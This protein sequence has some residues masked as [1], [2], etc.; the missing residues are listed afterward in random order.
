MALFEVSG[1]P[2]PIPKLDSRPKEMMS[3]NQ[4]ESGKWDIR[5]NA[6]SLNLLQTCLRKCQ[7][8]LFEGL[9]AKHEST[10]TLFGSAIHSAMEVFYSAPRNDRTIPPNMTKNLELMAH[11]EPVPVENDFLVYRAT[12]AFIDRAAPL[13]ALPPEDKR[14]IPNGVWTLGH[15]WKTYIQELND[16][17]VVVS[18]DGSP[19]VEKR[20]EHTFYDKDDMNI[21]LFGTIDAILENESNGQILIADHKTSSVVGKDFYNRLKPNH[22]YTCYTYLAQKCLGILTDNFLVNCIQ[23]KPKPKTARGQA[24]HFP[25]QI[26]KRTEED[27][28]HFLKTVE[29]YCRVAIS[30]KETGYWPMGPVEAC[31]AYGGCSFRKV[32]EVPDVVKENIIQMEYQ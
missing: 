20:L 24:P 25:R 10:A 4:L 22:Q 8:S 29:F 13:E 28:E 3:M 15:Y 14:S 17:Y 1:A 18:R 26:T 6:S 16:P 7:Y 23:V 2:H 11:G 27:I 21:T 5:I 32:C 30:A 31:G 12:R 9:R 19:L